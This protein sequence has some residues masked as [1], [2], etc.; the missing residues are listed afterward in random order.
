MLGP[1]KNTF[2]TALGVFSSF[3]AMRFHLGGI[4]YPINI[5]QYSHGLLNKLGPCKQDG[6][7]ISHLFLKLSMWLF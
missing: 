2:C 1:L 5:Q 4:Y 3:E 6:W 7:C